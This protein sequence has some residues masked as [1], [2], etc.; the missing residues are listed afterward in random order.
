VQARGDQ[1]HHFVL[2]IA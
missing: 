2:N 1:L